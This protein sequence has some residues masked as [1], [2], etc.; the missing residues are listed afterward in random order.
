VINHES[1]NGLVDADPIFG[2][3][4]SRYGV[5]PSWSRPEGFETMCRIILEQQV[6]LSSAKATYL[7]LCDLIDHVTPER[8]AMSS[9]EK[10]RAA[11]VSRQKASY[12]IGLAKEVL[13]GRFDF[14]L[15][16]EVSIEEA[17]ARLLSIRGIGQW[18][19]GVYLLFCLQAPD[20]FPSGDI[21]LIRTAKELWQINSSTDLNTYAEMRWKGYR[22]TAAFL[23][24]HFYLCKRN[25]EFV[26]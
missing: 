2:D 1:I 4:V 23:M 11:T 7:K 10:M 19:A 6:S 12:I 24:W 5:P 8:L 25:R 26:I 22:S 15:L 17:T 18:S 13:E 3:I 14:A 21:A 20:I 9:I 16:S